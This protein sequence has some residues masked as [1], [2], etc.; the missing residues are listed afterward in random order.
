MAGQ[1][2]GLDLDVCLGGGDA[3]EVFQCL[4]DIAQV[5]D[6]AGSCGNGIAGGGANFASGSKAHSA[7]AAGEHGKR[8]LA[9]FEVLWLGQDAAGDKAACRQGVLRPF[10]EQA[11]TLRAEAAPER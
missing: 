5:Q 6:V 2:A 10:D 1:L 3:L 8:E 11:D 4:L 9:A 7:Q